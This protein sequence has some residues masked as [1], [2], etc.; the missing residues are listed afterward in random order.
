LANPEIAAI[1]EVLAQTPGEQSLEDLRAMYDG[2]GTQ[3]PLPADVTVTPVSA[4]GVKA[5]WTSTPTADPDKVVIYLHG[6]GYVIGSLNSHRH[7]A[8]ELGRVAGA[9]TL[10]LDYALAPEVLYPQAVNDALAGYKYL[11]DQGIKPANIAIAG[12]SAGGGLTVAA[13]LAIKDAG[14][15]QPACGFAISPWA[16]LRNTNETMT[17]KSEED[18]MVQAPLLH[19]WADLYLGTTD[20]TTPLASPAFGDLTGL[21]PLLLHVG[22]A[23]TLLDDSHALARKAGAQGV[24]VQMEVWPEMIHVWHFFF[25]ILTDARKALA[26]AGGFIKAHMA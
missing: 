11:L 26:G 22:S 5:E 20:K 16:D 19:A 13:L 15:P 8:A 3:F 7:L 6:G 21:A 10:A 2:M 17:T 4:N 9:R 18:P 12:D 24:K 25:P 1:R 14:L 23:E